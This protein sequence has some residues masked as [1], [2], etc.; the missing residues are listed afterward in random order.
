MVRKMYSKQE[1]IY[2]IKQGNTEYG[3][4]QLQI[5]KVDKTKTKIG[6]DKKKERNR[7]YN[8]IDE[9]IKQWKKKKDEKL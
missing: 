4:I 7:E 5:W 8:W 6:N 9:K 1:N 2:T 3:N